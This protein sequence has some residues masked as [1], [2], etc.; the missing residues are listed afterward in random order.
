MMPL[1]RRSLG[2][3][4]VFFEG[5]NLKGHAKDLGNFLGQFSILADLVA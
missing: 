3:T 5:D 2:A 4:L 1:W